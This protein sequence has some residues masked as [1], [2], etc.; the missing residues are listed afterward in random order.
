MSATTEKKRSH[1][2]E[3]LLLYSPVLIAILVMIPRLLSPQFGL[4]DDGNSIV[5]AKK[6]AHGE[7]SFPVD[8]PIIVSD[9]FI[10]Y[11]L[12]FFITLLEK[13]L[14]GF[15]CLIRLCCA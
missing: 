4:F 14:F 5:T 7:W 3:M 1:A 12:R 8:V 9:H 15:S 6:I 13:S 11:R 2:L 10:G